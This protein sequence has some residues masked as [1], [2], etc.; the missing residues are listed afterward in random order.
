VRELKAIHVPFVLAERRKEQNLEA[1]GINNYI[2]RLHG[3]F[4]LA[5]DLG[6][7]SKNPAEQIELLKEPNPERLTLRG[8]R[9]NPS[10]Q[11]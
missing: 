9:L 5:F 7:V 8:T 2:R 6:A 10:L 4:G 11:R 3:L 1:A